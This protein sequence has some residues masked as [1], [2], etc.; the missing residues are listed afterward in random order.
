MATAVG[1]DLGTSSVLVY[2]TGKGIVL[3]EPS[4]V[5]YDRSLDMIRAVG[6]EAYL[7]LSRGDANLTAMRP[8]R[9]GIIADYKMTEEMVRYFIS[10]AIGRRSV[11][12]PKVC[13]CVPS[14]A[15]QVEVKA[16]LEA[17]YSVGAR[18]VELVEETVAAAFGAGIDAGKPSGSVIVDVGAGKTDVGVISLGYPVVSHCAPIGGDDFTQTIT[19]YIRKKHELMISDS[20][21]EEI[22]IQVG[23]I[24]PLV[25]DLVM[26]VTGRSAKTGMPEMIEVSSEEIREALTPVSDQI[27]E[28]VLTVLEQTPPEL[29]A[30][31]LARGIILTG[32]GARMRGLEPLIAAKTKIRTMTAKDPERAPALGIGKFLQSGRSSYL[33]P[34]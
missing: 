12:K 28:A 1:L 15:T 29:C 10:K 31:I 21:A 16:V 4:V 19:D 23:T 26:E 9:R 34:I 7:L 11:L 27:V 30:D 18:D 24:Y 14:D 5:A 8:L 22:K 32:G 6:E 13:L 17:G 2:V 25:N 3:K 33:S 20:Q